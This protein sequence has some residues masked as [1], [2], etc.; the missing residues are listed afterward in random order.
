MCDFNYTCTRSS[1]ID[2]EGDEDMAI[3]DSYLEQSQSNWGVL[4]GEDPQ[5]DLNS[6]RMKIKVPT[7]IREYW[8]LTSRCTACNSKC[9]MA[10]KN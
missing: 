8:K 1:E 6:P 5:L 3:Q 10:Y 7:C 2:E 4:C 9:I